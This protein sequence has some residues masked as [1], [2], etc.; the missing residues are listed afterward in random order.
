MEKHLNLSGK[1]FGPYVLRSRIG[2]GGYGAV[3]K[4]INTEN[5]ETYA[6]KVLKPIRK[7][8]KGYEHEVEA[9]KILSQ[10]PNCSEFVV[11]MFDFG[12]TGS[13]RRTIFGKTPDKYYF[14]VTELMDNNLKFL[15]RRNI[16]IGDYVYAYLALQL[17]RG[18]AFIHKRKLA[19]RDI[20]LENILYRISNPVDNKVTLS[21]ALLNLD[22]AMINFEV[23]Y[24][25]LGFTC[26]SEDVKGED[27]ELEYVQD[28]N[29][30]KGTPYYLSPELIDLLLKKK[31]DIDVII[32]QQADIWALGITLYRFI[33]LKLPVF[34]QGT[35]NK[36]QI[37]NRLK[38]LS[39]KD[40]DGT[41]ETTDFDDVFS[42]PD[43]GEVMKSLLLQTLRVDPKERINP[44]EAVDFLES[45]LF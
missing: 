39:Q 26:T 12:I 7:V 32:G 8:I 29:A 11:C 22:N 23:K 40:V 41:I 27:P 37:V 6:M 33:F 15:S 3:Y 16:E 14:M 13:R 44:Q 20:K 17:F 5:D 36:N 9:H 43:V 21:E 2:T 31:L 35:K 1:R 4:V 34:L 24:A 30:N 18:L 19:H 45:Q 28:C 38:T 42:D 10:S 25:D